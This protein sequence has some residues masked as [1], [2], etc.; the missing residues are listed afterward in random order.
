MIYVVYAAVGLIVLIALPVIVAALRPSDFRVA[1]SLAITASPQRLFPYINNL[2]KFQE[3]NPYRD[4]DPQARNEFLGPEEGPGALF[5]WDGDGNVGAGIMRIVD[6]V[7]D[8]QVNV[9]LEFLRP[10]AA[11]NTV[12]FSLAPDSS[13]T[14]VTWSME[15]RYALVPKIVGLVI[16]MDRMIGGDFETGLKRLKSLAEGGAN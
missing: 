16:N 3:W 7:P 9:D 4:K 2:K 15:G 8:R 6:H 12:A 5:R 11:H 13:G 1:R 10:F 14:V